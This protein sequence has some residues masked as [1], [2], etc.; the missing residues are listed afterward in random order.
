VFSCRQKC[1]NKSS[2]IY[3]LCL[4]YNINVWW[5]LRTIVLLWPQHF[6][7][8]PYY[9]TNFKHRILK[10]WPQFLKQSYQLCINCTAVYRISNFLNTVHFVKTHSDLSRI[11]MFCCCSFCVLV[12]L[13]DNFRTSSASWETNSRSGTQ[14]TLCI[15]CDTRVHYH[16]HKS[17]ACGLQCGIKDCEIRACLQSCLSKRTYRYPSDRVLVVLP[18]EAFLTTDELFLRAVTPP[19]AYLPVLI[20]HPSCNCGVCLCDRPCKEGL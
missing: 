1:L 20:V 16:V 6:A 9:R 4:Y 12:D 18:D 3:K 11:L 19:V 13:V 10:F 5:F 2:R 14:K 17:P 15:V 8:P 7:R